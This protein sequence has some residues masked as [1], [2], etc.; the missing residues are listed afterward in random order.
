MSRILVVEDE[1]AMRRALDVNLRARGYEV[2][3][4]ATGEDALAV[5]AAGPPDLVVLDLGL[6][7]LDGLEVIRGLRGWSPVPIL[8]LSARDDEATKIAALDAGADD[9]VT[10]PFAVGELLARVRAM[11][12]RDAADHTATGAAV[13][14]TAH[15]TIDRA[16]RTVTAGGQPVRLTPIEWQMLELLVTHPDRLVT[17][18]QLLEAVWGTAEHSDPSLLRV[19]MANLRRKLEPDPAHPRHLVTEPG[20]GYRFVPDP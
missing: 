20:T 19:H 17:R 18:R 16:H 1:A 9:Y 8:V 4:A 2:R 14:R 13:V 11:L 6:P 7:G 15:L 3:L 10:K 12:R 5:A